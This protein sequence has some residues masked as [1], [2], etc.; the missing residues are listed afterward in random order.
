MNKRTRRPSNARA[1]RAASERKKSS[2]PGQVMIHFHAPSNVPWYRPANESDHVQVFANATAEVVPCPES[3]LLK[4][5]QRTQH[6]LISRLFDWKAIERV[7]IIPPLP[8]SE[9]E[10]ANA[11][12]A[13]AES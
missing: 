2:P 6:G 8:L 13:A 10:E 3:T 4:V 5:A 9:T 1:Q 7:T 11:E 12:A